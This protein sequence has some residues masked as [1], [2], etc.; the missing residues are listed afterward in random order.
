MAGAVFPSEWLARH[1]NQKEMYALYHLLL[2]FCEQHPTVLRR[3]RVMMN[4][5]NEAVVG[6][7]NR[8][9]AKNRAAHNI[10]IELLNLQ[11][12]YD[13]M[14]S[15]KW[16]PTAANGVADA[17]SRP[18]REAIVRLSRAAFRSLWDALGPFSID[19][20]ACNASVQLSP[21]TGEPLPLFSR[22]HCEGAAGTDMLAQD[23]AVMP[24]GGGVAFGFCF[25][26]PLMVGM[27]F[28]ICANAKPML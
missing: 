16:I 18:S 13:F 24:G 10:L 8:V 25:P 6:A 21:A 2:Q 3:T 11:V 19:L 1:I 17:I 4:V 9:R 14:L 22:F 12:S 28:N 23:V 26:P 27:L 7:F 5:D 20:M 15:L